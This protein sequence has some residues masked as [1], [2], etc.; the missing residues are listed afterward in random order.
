MIKA[1]GGIR[2]MSRTYP[3]DKEPIRSDI[4]RGKCLLL[5]LRVSLITR[6]S[7]CYS[8][9]T[10]VGGLS[11]RTAR[12]RSRGAKSTGRDRRQ[13]ATGGVFRSSGASV[14]LPSEGRTPDVNPRV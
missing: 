14:P 5:P 11:V 8:F 12:R 3:C 10:V 1:R 9:T 4:S 7:R 2:G 13:T 6:V